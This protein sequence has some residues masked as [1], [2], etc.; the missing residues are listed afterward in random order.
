MGIEIPVIDISQ[1]DKACADA[2]VSAA[3]SYGFVFIK[4]I[5]SGITTDEIDKMFQI[6]RPTSESFSNPA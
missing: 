6:V 5:G 2:L 1:P 4:L 3:A